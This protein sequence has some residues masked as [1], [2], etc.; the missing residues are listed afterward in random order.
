MI[1]RHIGEKMM[2]QKVITVNS[3]GWRALLDNASSIG[4]IEN[5]DVKEERISQISKHIASKC[6]HEPNK[7][8]ELEGCILLGY[9]EDGKEPVDLKRFGK[10]FTSKYKDELD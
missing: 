6:G 2:K 4:R 10:L 3:A 7:M 1:L 9:V 8:I 5:Q